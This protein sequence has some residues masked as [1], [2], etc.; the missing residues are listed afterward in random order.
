MNIPQAQTAERYEPQTRQ[1]PVPFRHVMASCR[2]SVTVASAHRA[3][4]T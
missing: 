1:V 2:R 4:R 3:S